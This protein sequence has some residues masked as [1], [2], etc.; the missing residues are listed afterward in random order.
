MLLFIVVQL[1]D[2]N[3]SYKSTDLDD[4]LGII[5]IDSNPIIFLKDRKK[6]LDYYHKYITD[7]K[8]FSRFHFI[9]SEL[10]I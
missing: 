5:N 7:D 6:C 10:G 3:S 4:E 9:V 2:S 1:Y 8:F